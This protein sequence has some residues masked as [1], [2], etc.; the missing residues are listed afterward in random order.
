MKKTLSLPLFLLLALVTI[1]VSSSEASAFSLFGNDTKNETEIRSDTSINA[2]STS[3]S[4]ESSV[5]VRSQTSVNANSSTTQDDGRG[6]P[7]GTS[8]INSSTGAAGIIRISRNSVENET[9]TQN[10]VTVTSGEVTS[11]IQLR[12]YASN[13][14]RNDENLQEMN[15][16]EESVKVSY[17]ERGHIVGFIPV[18]INVTAEA[19][20]NG[21][22]EVKYPWYFLVMLKNKQDLETQLINEVRTITA[23]R[24]D[25]EFDAATQAQ[26][27]ARMHMVLKS[28]FES[29]ADNAT[30]TRT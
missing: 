16:S 3:E 24:N 12:S 1:A 9:N 10:E 5:N 6:T 13:A 25:Q 29:S 20:S 8:S 22:V 11:D 7:T 19:K 18:T 23:V 14:I 15:F 21:D 17:K 30:E 4:D 28:H 27:A 2:E 26:I